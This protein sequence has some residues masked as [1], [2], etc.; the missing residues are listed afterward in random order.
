MENSS[1]IANRPSVIFINKTDIIKDIKQF[2]KKR[3]NKSTS[4]K[5]TKKAVV[6]KIKLEQQPEEEIKSK[7]K[8]E[9]IEYDDLHR[10]YNL[11]N[12][13]LIILKGFLVL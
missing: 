6:K 10:V 12:N 5:P 8:I 11:H 3:K 9:R 4:I 7:L 1:P 13:K 2:A